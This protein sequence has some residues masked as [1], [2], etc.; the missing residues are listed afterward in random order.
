M[1]QR[2]AARGPPRPARSSPPGRTRRRP[3]RRT[4]STATS[5]RPRRTGCGWSTSPTSPTWAGHGVHRV[6]VRRLLPPDRRLAHRRPR[7]RPSCRWTRW[8]WRCGPAAAPA[9]A[10]ST[11]L[12]HHRDAGSQYTAIRYTDRLADAGALAS[13][14]T[15][16]DSSTTLRSQARSLTS[17]PPENMG[18][19][20]SG[21]VG[22]Y[23]FRSRSADERPAAAVANAP[24]AG[25]LRFGPHSLLTTGPPSGGLSS[26]AT[27]PSPLPRGGSRRGAGRRSGPG[28]RPSGGGGPQAAGL[29]AG[30]LRRLRPR[31]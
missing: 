9:D 21:T 16:G 29:A 1:R 17:P 31:R 12:V 25:S 22:L 24:L 11:G 6:R 27:W 5:P 4:W 10:R 13:I 23:R 30:E 2:R 14:G 20:S 18:T 3:G 28:L 8:R 19:R 7:C 15:V 26:R